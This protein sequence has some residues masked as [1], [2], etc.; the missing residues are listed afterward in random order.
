MKNDKIIMSDFYADIYDYINSKCYINNVWTRP[1]NLSDIVSIDDIIKSFSGWGYSEDDIKYCYETIKNNIENKKENKGLTFGVKENTAYS[2]IIQ[3]YKLRFIN[4]ITGYNIISYCKNSPDIQTAIIRACKSRDQYNKRFPHQKR[5]IKEATLEILK[6]K[7]LNK[8]N[9][10][11]SVNNFDDLFNIIVNTGV[12]KNGVNSLTVYDVALRIGFYLNIFPERIYLH[13][14]TRTGVENLL[15]KKIKEYF[16]F[17][18]DLQEPFKSCDL[19]E[20]QLEDLFCEYKLKI[21][22][23]KK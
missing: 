17:K 2:E 22:E 21:Q 3:D 20:Y 1:D 14:G 10:I 5:Y 8:S 15:N 4:R 16:I 6:N 9:D 7:L 13:A 18:N 19:T 12:F 23:I 11:N